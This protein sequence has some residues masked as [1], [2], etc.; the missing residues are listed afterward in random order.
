LVKSIALIGAHADSGV[1]SGGGSAQVDPPGGGASV[2]GGPAVWFPSSPMKAI[3]AHAPK[4]KVEFND[5]TDVAAAA[6]LAKAAEIAIVVVNEPTSEG[7]D[8]ATLTLSNK[9][10]DLVRAVA[11]ANPRTIVVLETGGPALMPWIGSVSAAL[12]IWY[13]GVK[14]AEALANILFGDANPCG[15]LPVT[16]PKTEADLPHPTIPGHGMPMMAPFDADYAFEGLKVGYKWFDA[17]N[18]EPLFPFGFG[19][20]Y[21]T[22]AYSG[23]KVNLDSVSF[24]VRNTGKRAG[25]EVAEVYV[26][27]PAA[28]QEPPKR[29]VAWEKIRLAPGES[30][31]V[32]L[33]LEPKFLSIF[34][35]QKDDWELLSG[36]YKFFVGGSSRSTPLSAT[37]KR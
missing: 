9:Q 33:K 35:E 21:S 12:E 10:D 8:L 7:K 37:V 29:L 3:R 1:L 18:K 5:G 14:G 28:A 24:T 32:T 26:S 19:L 36:E 34:S 4:A 27:L 23:L 11:A 6:A 22:Y 2:F 31:T 25:A 16:F 15:K 20:S 13:P 30:K 17:E